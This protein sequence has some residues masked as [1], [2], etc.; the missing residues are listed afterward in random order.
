M[1]RSCSCTQVREHQ[2]CTPPMHSWGSTGGLSTH[3]LYR[4]S[5]QQRMTLKVAKFHRC[6]PQTSATIVC[7]PSLRKEK[8]LFT[9]Q[10]TLQRGHLS[11]LRG[12]FSV[13]REQ[14]YLLST[15]GAGR[16]DT[17]APSVVLH[18]NAA[19]LPNP[20]HLILLRETPNAHWLVS[21][22]RT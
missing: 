5:S 13:E 17:L 8:S 18:L 3:V 16:Y 1:R 15:T 4:H 9:R 19:A 12:Q 20:V 10:E 6:L 14:W 2:V 11:H 7:H 22:V 21:L